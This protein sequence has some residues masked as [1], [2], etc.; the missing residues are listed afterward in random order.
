MSGISSEPPLFFFLYSA[1]LSYFYAPHHHFA[2]LISNFSFKETIKRNQGTNRP[3]GYPLPSISTL[4]IKNKHFKIDAVLNHRDTMPVVRAAYST[5]QHVSS[6]KPSENS[7]S[8]GILIIDKGYLSA[9]SPSSPAEIF[10]RMFCVIGT[11]S[12]EDERPFT[13]AC[14]FRRARSYVFSILK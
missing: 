6:C 11:F 7:A 5:D 12:L 14:T 13:T 4:T 1:A 10:Q 9:F 8:G 2:F 3:T